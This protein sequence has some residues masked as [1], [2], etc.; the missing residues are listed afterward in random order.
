MTRME[1]SDDPTTG[2]TAKKGYD[3]QKFL[4]NFL[5]ECTDIHNSTKKKPDSL[6][7]W[8]DD[9]SNKNMYAFDSLVS[10]KEIGD[11]TVENCNEDGRPFPKSTHK[12]FTDDKAAMVAAGVD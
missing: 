7:L 11:S 6:I 9:V 2:I 5:Y 4:K 8:T 10:E 1:Q 12:E 3:F